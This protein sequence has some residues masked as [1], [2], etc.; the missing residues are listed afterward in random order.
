MEDCGKFSSVLRSLVAVEF[1]DDLVEVLAVVGRNGS[2]GDKA[3]EVLPWL[4]DGIGKDGCIVGG[5]GNSFGID[6]LTGLVNE[7]NKE[8]LDSFVRP[9]AFGGMVW[10]TADVLTLPDLA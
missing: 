6:P 9:Q 3:S 7:F 4:D 8:V 10:A 2:D 5:H 1:D